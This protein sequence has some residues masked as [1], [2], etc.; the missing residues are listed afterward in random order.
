MM[1][2]TPWASIFAIDNCTI[3]GDF[4]LSG[5]WIELVTITSDIADLLILS[6]ASPDR[7]GW[8]ATT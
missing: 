2:K 3:F 5:N 8:V 1:F 6:T 4:L 7:I